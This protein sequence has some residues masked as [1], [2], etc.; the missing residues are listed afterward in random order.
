MSSIKT[1]SKRRLLATVALVAISCLT[2]PSVW[3]AEADE[4]S[5]PAAS[6]ALRDWALSGNLEIPGVTACHQCEW[7]P[8]P[9]QMRAA[10]QCGVGPD[11][12]PK[13][14]EFE[15]GFSEDCKRVCN[16]VRCLTP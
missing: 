8:K 7:R 13:L 1:P 4:P 6:K 16:F 15:C 12:N 9:N 14:A 10:D 3:A 5:A 2:W 11:G